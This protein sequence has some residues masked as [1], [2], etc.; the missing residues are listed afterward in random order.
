M[1]FCSTSLLRSPGRLIIT[2]GHNYR[3]SRNP[4]RSQLFGPEDFEVKCFT[5][6]SCAVAPSN[7]STPAS[8]SIVYRRIVP[9]TTRNNSTRA[10]SVVA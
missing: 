7:L 5:S 3:G 9:N 2:T 10:A 6:P 4:L 8:G 1:P